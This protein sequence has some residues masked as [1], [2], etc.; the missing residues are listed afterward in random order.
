MPS[1]RR[2]AS[3]GVFAEVLPGDKASY[4]AKLQEEG[5]VVGMVG[6]GIN[7]APA[8]AQADVGMAIGTGDGCGHGDGRCHAHAR[9]SAQRAPGHPAFPRD[10][11]QHPAESGLGLRLQHRPDPDRGRSVWLRSPGRPTSCV[12]S[13]RSWRPAPWPSAASASSAT[14]CGCG[15]SN[16][17][18]SRQKALVSSW[19]RQHSRIAVVA[20]TPN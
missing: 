5:F 11:A 1:R 12:S 14:H 18:E 9:R 10:H 13:T 16:S 15:G 2:S 8:L 3:T 19:Q 20:F 7:D 4:V 6:D 17:S